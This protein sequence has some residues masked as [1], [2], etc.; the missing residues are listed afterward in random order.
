MARKTESYLVDDFDGSK[1][2]NTIP[3]SYR[4]AE[5]EIDLSETNAREFDKDMARYIDAGRRVRNG[6]GMRRSEERHQK[7]QAAR[8]WLRE[9]GYDIGKQGRIPKAWLEEFEKF[10]RAQGQRGDT[11]QTTGT[12]G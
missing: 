8:A 6:R 2:A 4:G 3:F 9:Q 7:L 5:Y 1:P 11:A 12:D 10:E